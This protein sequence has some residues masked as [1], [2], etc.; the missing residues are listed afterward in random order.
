MRGA[1][2]LRIG[3]DRDGL[4]W[5]PRAYAPT[6]PAP[7]LVLLHGA[8]GDAERTLRWSRQAAEDAGIILL[9]PES[10]GRTWDVL[11]GGFGPDVAFIDAALEAAFERCVID[12]NRVAIG[13]FSDGASY[14]LSLGI[15][16]GDLFQHV[17]AF[18][19]GFFMPLEVTGN[20]RLFISH[21]AQDQ[22]LPIAATSQMIVPLLKQLGYDLDYLEFDGPHAIPPWVLDRG[23]AW[24]LGTTES[25][26]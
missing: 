7:L 1:N 23:L 22:V 17:L 26:G 14:A 25:G 24:Y 2:P 20:P 13:G 11:V 16:N 21:G 4:L 8:G 6:R 5:I 12:P 10:S 19:P 3:N 9:V 15:I 18:S